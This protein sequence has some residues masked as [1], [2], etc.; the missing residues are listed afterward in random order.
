MAAVVFA[1]YIFKAYYPQYIEIVQI[2]SYGILVVAPH[3]SVLFRGLSPLH[4]LEVVKKQ[5]D[6]CTDEFY[7]LIENGRPM[8][9]RQRKARRLELEELQNVFSIL[10]EQTLTETH[11]V[12]CLWAFLRGS[13]Y[14]LY[15]HQRRIESLRFR[16][17]LESRHSPDL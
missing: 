12:G 8:S 14:R 9:R 11:H 2:L 3:V 15:K 4:R 17:V 16:L 10:K 6:L 5:L 1:G 7:G 13:S